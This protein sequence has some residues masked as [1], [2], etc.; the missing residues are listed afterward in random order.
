MI[1]GVLGGASI[2]EGGPLPLTC[3][4]LMKYNIV[5]KKRIKKVTIAV[6]WKVK[7]CL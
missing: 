1:E 7:G 2:K 5:G 6:W 4:Y 3:D